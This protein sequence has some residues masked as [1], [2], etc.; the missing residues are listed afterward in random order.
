MRPT[1]ILFYII[2]LCIHKSFAQPADSVSLQLLSLEKQYYQTTDPTAKTQIAMQ[3][4]QV[5]ID[6]HIEGQSQCLGECSRVDTAYVNEIDKRRYLWN[7]ALMYFLHKDY[8]HSTDLLL[9]Y[10]QR[11][12]DTSTSLQLLYVLSAQRSPYDHIVQVE[13]NAAM[14]ELYTCLSAESQQAQKKKT[15][16][17][18]CAYIVPG[19]GMVLKGYPAKGAASF[20]LNAASAFWVVA[21]L[22]KG[23]YVN[24]FS[25]GILTT[26][27]FY[28]G[29]IQYTKKLSRRKENRKHNLVMSRCHQQLETWLV[30]YPINFK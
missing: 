16:Y 17:D 27:K 3:K 25:Y 7:A 23:L 8:A 14:Q 29:N 30:Q 6:N 2:L 24:A 11:Y 4:M 18:W 9:S 5:Y 13:L 12:Q 22:Q 28:A 15:Q 10:K 26:S 19:S 20:L 1:I 21:L